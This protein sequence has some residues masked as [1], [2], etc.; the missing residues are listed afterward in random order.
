MSRDTPRKASTFT[1]P[2]SYVLHRF[3]SS[4]KAIGKVYRKYRQSRRAGFKLTWHASIVAQSLDGIEPAGA[5]GGVI[6]EE[7]AD[8]RGE[9][10]SEHRPLHREGE[11][12]LR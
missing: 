2:R 12:P 11:G 4:I 9:H 3:R 8:R 10:Q 6:A 5:A 7:E 1:S